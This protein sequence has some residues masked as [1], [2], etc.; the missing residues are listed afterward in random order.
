[1]H[2]QKVVYNMLPQV[3]TPV[4]NRLLNDLSKQLTAEVAALFDLEEAPLTASLV[5]VI[6]AN[7]ITADT[8][9]GP[10][11]TSIDDLLKMVN[12]EAVVRIEPHEVIIKGIDIGNQSI[13]LITALKGGAF[14]GTVAV[15]YV[16]V[17]GPRLQPFVTG[18]VK[19]KLAGRQLA[20]HT[21]K[22]MET[23]LAIVAAYQPTV[24]AE[25]KA[26]D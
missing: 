2:K 14:S 22:G 24:P 3:S 7:H 17:H 5:R 15:S 1:M 20:N 4:P 16:N 25:E 9:I 10:M 12:R 18:S 11:M 6:G 26:N 13:A 8:P 19:R 23:M 21:L